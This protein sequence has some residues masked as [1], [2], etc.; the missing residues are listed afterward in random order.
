[1]N[2]T[3]C[4]IKLAKQGHNIC[5]TGSGGV[6]KTYQVNAMREAMPD[7][8]IAMTASTG[9]AA[10]HIGGMTLHSFF[11]IAGS[12][13]DS[14]FKKLKRSERWQKVVNRLSIFDLIVIDEVSMVRSDLLNYV[15]KICKEAMSDRWLFAMAFDFDASEVDRAR[16]Q[17]KAE[18]VKLLPFGGKQMVFVGDFMQLPPVV[19]YRERK[20]ITEP[21][22]FQSEAW[23]SANVKTIH[24]TK[25]MRQSD[26]EFIG[27]LQNIRMGRVTGR[28]E[29]YLKKRLIQ[30]PEVSIKVLPTNKQVDEINYGELDKI[31]ENLI[32]LKAGYSILPEI[33]E[34]ASEADIKKL[35][36]IMSKSSNLKRNL[37][38]KKGCRILTLKNDEQGRFVNGSMGTF[39]KACRAFDLTIQKYENCLQAACEDRSIP[40]QLVDNYLVLDSKSAYEKLKEV[41]PMYHRTGKVELGECQCLWLKINDRDVFVERASSEYRSGEYIDNLTDEVKPDIT[42]H[43]FPVTLAY[44]LTMHKCQGMTVDSI[45][46]DFDKCN[47]EGAAYVALSRS[48]NFEGLYLENFSRYSIKANVDAL[49]F[50]NNLEEISF[51]ELCKE[52][53][54]QLNEE[55]K[56]GQ[57]VIDWAKEEG[58]L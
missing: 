56:E 39:V 11:G 26:E 42:M 1:M 52:E 58:M 45:K 4:I 40:F 34:N 44:A 41:F 10:T 31:Q 6:G 18:E 50:Y 37:L 36:I 23:K 55:E 46:I 15:D 13:K 25:I 49:N 20:D 17:K 7:K 51:E 3:D 14:D 22:A 33:E 35:Y 47:F 2:I 19:T 30:A 9:L 24:L 57:S 21:W 8:R 29:K 27:A 54:I 38:L 5:I 48:R 28:I 12:Y 53:K 16:Y 43:Q 32:E